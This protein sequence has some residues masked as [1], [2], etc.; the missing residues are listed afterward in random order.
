MAAAGGESVQ[1]RQYASRIRLFSPGKRAG[2]LDSTGLTN[3]ENAMSESADPLYVLITVPFDKE[4]LDQFREISDR[5]TILDYPTDQA[6]DVP[7]DVWAKA[8]V[9]YT[10]TVLPDPALAPRLRWIQAHSAGVNH[11]LDQPIIQAQEVQLTTSSG[12]HA[13]TV[14]EYV[15]MMMLA[16]GHR[17]PAMIEH[18]AATNWPDEGRY[19]TF[20]P[21][22]LRG[23]TVGIVGYGSIGREIARVAHTFNMEVLAVKRDVRHPT[24]TDGY[25]LPGT[26]DPEGQHFHRLYPPEAL[27]SMVRECDFVVLVTP[28]TESTRLMFDAEVFAAM[29]D[30]AYLINV[31]R[32]GVVDE[33]A[34]LNALQN[35]QIAGAAM[36]VFASEPLPADSPLWKQPNLIISPHIAG[37]SRDYNAKAAALFAENLKRYLE[38][39]DLLNL[40]DRTRGY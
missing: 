2:I 24:D 20:L 11:L 18:K 17:L 1:L 33:Q 39:K 19:E 32:G 23:S 40:V 4:T 38:R 31:S 6:R 13:T 28:L 26:G 30:T 36:D 37:N 3:L 21:L 8:E 35:K 16:F 27:I 14:T 12:I 34:L 7:D 10:I 29:K 22:E 9:L 15:F 5:V 25:V